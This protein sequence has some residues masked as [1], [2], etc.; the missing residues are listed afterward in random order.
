MGRIRANSGYIRTKGVGVEVM[1]ELASVEDVMR[2][3]GVSKATVYRWAASGVLKPIQL[4]GNG[5][6]IEH[7]RRLRFHQADI[8]ALI[9]GSK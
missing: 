3:F 4:P 8:A 2:V 7:L 5:E 9:E 6:R 1:E